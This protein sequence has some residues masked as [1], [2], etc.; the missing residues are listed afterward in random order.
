[1]CPHHSRLAAA[2]P[3]RRGQRFDLFPFSV[4]FHTLS[5]R[6]LLAASDQSTDF[7]E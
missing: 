2:A 4:G 7:I 5:M 3:L 6:F 1:M